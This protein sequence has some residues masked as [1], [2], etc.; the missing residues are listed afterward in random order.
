MSL[1]SLLNGVA[2]VSTE[3]WELQSPAKA[4]R[5]DHLPVRSESS[6]SLSVL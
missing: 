4:R 6:H 5:S 2:T 3:S 1:R